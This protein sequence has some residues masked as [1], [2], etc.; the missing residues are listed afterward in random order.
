MRSLFL[1][2]R[3]YC[4]I[5]WRLGLIRRGTAFQWE[6]DA[7]LGKY[8]RKASLMLIAVL[9]VLLLA[10][11]GCKDPYGG[12]AKAAADIASGIATGMSTVASLQRSGAI[13]A[14]EAL[15]V[16]GYLEYAN[17]GD[18]AFITCIQAAHGGSK[19]GAFTACANQFNTTL[20]NPQQ[21]ALIHVSNSQASQTISVIVTGVTTAVA[22]IIS[23]LGGK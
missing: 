20:N 14:R 2:L 21:L 18:E 15:N 9:P 3:G 1:R 17:Q 22:L 8:S 6:M 10:S 11:A 19:A 5:V 4:G 13:S 12:S 16:L 7:S 23:N